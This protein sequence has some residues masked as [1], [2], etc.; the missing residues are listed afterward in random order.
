MIKSKPTLN[1]FLVLD[2][3][4]VIREVCFVRQVAFSVVV[5]RAAMMLQQC[6]LMFGS[7]FMLLWMEWIWSELSRGFQ[8]QGNIFCCLITS[9]AYDYN[10]N[11]KTWTNQF[12]THTQTL[13]LHW[14]AQSEFTAIEWLHRS[15]TE[16]QSNASW[17][18]P[19]W[20]NWDASRLTSKPIKPT[21]L[22]AV[23]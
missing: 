22:N 4:C 20:D 18:F 23:Y 10:S 3:D 21:S 16:L 17:T 6:V 12:W 2:L 11:S 1:P 8:H 7:L 5:M 19:T 13:P 9:T 14:R 15:L